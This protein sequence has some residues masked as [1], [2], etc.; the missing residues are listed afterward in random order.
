MTGSVIFTVHVAY[1]TSRVAAYVDVVAVALVL[2]TAQERQVVVTQEMLKP[3][4][5][6]LQV[7]TA[8]VA[9]PKAWRVQPT[10]ESVSDEVVSGRIWPFD[11]RGATAVERTVPT[12]EG[13]ALAKVTHR[14]L[15]FSIEQM[16]GASMETVGAELAKLSKQHASM[17]DIPQHFRAQKILPKPQR[18]VVQRSAMPT[19]DSVTDQPVARAEQEVSPEDVA[20]PVVQTAVVKLPQPTRAH[21]QAVEL[22]PELVSEG[23]TK[24]SEEKPTTWEVQ[25]QPLVA[26][27]KQPKPSRAPVQVCEWL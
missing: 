6:K 9:Q 2:E 17:E 20:A 23:I 7:S 11:D 18:T 12:E 13:P 4:E 19:S 14:R 5:I 10:H 1:V 15:S 3:Q 22:R 8:K 25:F 27:V 21:V 16:P 26:T 24:A